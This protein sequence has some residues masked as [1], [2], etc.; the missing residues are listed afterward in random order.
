MGLKYKARSY[1]EVHVKGFFTC[2]FNQSF[3]VIMSFTLLSVPKFT[4][5]YC[6]AGV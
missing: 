3:V 4:A 2:E 6:S 5:I 1:K